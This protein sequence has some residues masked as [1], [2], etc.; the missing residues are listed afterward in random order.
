VS[1]P[2]PT[3]QAAE[4]AMQIRKELVRQDPASRRY[5]ADLTSTQCAIGP[6]LAELGRDAEAQ[7]TVA[8]ALASAAALHSEFPESLRYRLDVGLAHIASGAVHWRALRLSL[9]DSEWLTGLSLM[10][11]ALQD[12]PEDNPA[13]NDLDQAR[14]DVANKLFQ[15]GLWEEAGE[16]FDRVFRRNPSSLSIYGGHYWHLHAM[17]RKFTG[18]D[19]GYHESRAVFIKEFRAFEYRFNVFRACWCGSG[20]T[21]LFESLAPQAEVERTRYH[22]DDWYVLN[23]AM[24]SFRAGQPAKALE[25]TKEGRAAFFDCPF[26]SA[27]MALIHYQLGHRTEALAALA[28][29]DR[30]VEDEFKACLQGPLKPVVREWLETVLIHELVRREVHALVDGHP[31]QDV[32]Y[33]HLIR[34]RGLARMGRS[35]DA[36]LA[37]ATAR[38]SSNDDPDLHTL[39]ASIQAE[40]SSR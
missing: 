20:P 21:A 5:R 27:M 24:V 22:N 36:E 33:R 18:D 12:E 32:P 2:V 26:A 37:F 15:L 8:E 16:L 6:L 35:R 4:K 14:I 19:R 38:R 9:A 30:F 7:R 31:G 29:S 25:I 40:L 11:A 3:L 28:K 39:T 10:E 1:A 34:A 23:S 13:R 17:L